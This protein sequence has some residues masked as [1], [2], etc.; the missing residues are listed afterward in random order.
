MSNLSTIFGSSGSTTDPR[1]EGLP[2]FGMW[3]GSSDSNTQMQFRVFD[4]NFRVTGSPWGSTCDTTTNYRFGILA[5]ASHA[6][7]M[8]DHGDNFHN[9]LTTEGYDSWTK[10]IK[11]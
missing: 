1:K 8:K 2:L 9:N 11:S 4:S 3:G 5:D 6:Y 10:Y 7:N